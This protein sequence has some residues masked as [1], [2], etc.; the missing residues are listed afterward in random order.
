MTIYES[1]S[2]LASAVEIMVDD[3][4]GLHKSTLRNAAMVSWPI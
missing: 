1:T 4:K 3:L 2:T